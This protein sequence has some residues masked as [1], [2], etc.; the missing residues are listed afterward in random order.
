MQIFPE[1]QKKKE[2]KCCGKT[3]E[4][5]LQKG[6]KWQD[7]IPETA[8]CGSCKS[9]FEK[10]SEKDFAYKQSKGK[11]EY[12]CTNCKSEVKAVNRAHSIHDGPFPLSGGGQCEYEA[13]PYCPRD[14]QKPSA[15]GSAITVP[16]RF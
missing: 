12:K 9:H 8:D 4:F 6:D 11:G 10:K 2:I 16:F 3:L 1:F 15:Y 5:I 14:E 13:I 7:Y